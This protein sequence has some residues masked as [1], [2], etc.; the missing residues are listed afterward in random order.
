[1]KTSRQRDVAIA[2]VLFAIGYAAGSSYYRHFV[3]SGGRPQY[4]QRQLDASMMLACGRG[5]VALQNPLPVPVDAFLL[6]ESESIACSD[7]PPTLKTQPADVYQRVS[8]YLLLSVAGLWWLSGPSWSALVPLFGVLFG[9][10]A[11]AAYALFR[12]G[13][14]RTLASLASLMF[15][16]S[17]AQYQRPSAPARLCQGAIRA[18]RHGACRVDRVA[19]AFRAAPHSALCRSGRSRWNRSGVSDGP[20]ADCGR[21]AGCHPV[22]ACDRTR[23]H[24][25]KAVALG[26]FVLAFV[27][28]ALPILRAYGGGNNIWHVTVLG[29]M[30][31]F[32]EPLGISTPFY[33]LGR[34]YHDEYVSMA[35][36]SYSVRVLGNPDALPLASKA[37][38]QA[39]LSYFKEV[40]VTMP[41]DLMIRVYASIIHILKLPFD[42]TAAPPEFMT[43]GTIES[44]YAVRARLLAWIAPVIPFLAAAVLAGVS[45]VSVRLAIF[46]VFAIALFA[47]MPALQ[48]HQRHF[49]HLEVI[50]WLLLG[51][52]VTAA[53]TP[54]ARS[55][56]PARNGYG[57]R[58]FWQFSQY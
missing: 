56:R 1:M 27:L 50:G 37:Y 3:R 8:R 5:F 39:S 32:D 30:S 4:Y 36:N 22:R 55:G 2:L 9:A 51:V 14:N 38:E 57:R 19:S 13:M 15:L 48:Y 24:R 12:V 41:A 31:A 17:S 28:S 58:P 42:S 47:G 52:A 54:F 25:V 29:M 35:I 43:G 21:T 23:G 16:A 7:I 44:F 20:A 10:S 33:S 53:H 49:F 11:A 45:S 40:L 34:L 46:W 18:G 6:Q 26:A